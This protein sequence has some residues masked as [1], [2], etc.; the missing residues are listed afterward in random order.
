MSAKVEVHLMPATRAELEAVCRSQSVGAARR[1]GLA[2]TLP[3]KR[4]ATPG[5]PP[6]FDGAAEARLVTLQG[7]VQRPAERHRSVWS[8][9]GQSPRVGSNDV[10]ECDLNSMKS[11]GDLTLLPDGVSFSSALKAL[12]ESLPFGTSIAIPRN[13]FDKQR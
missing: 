1:D 5:T 2:G 11:F 9:P 13:R 8:L 7:R 10:R 4:H 6:K 12:R 3:R